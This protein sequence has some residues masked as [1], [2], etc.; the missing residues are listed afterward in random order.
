M[1]HTEP[2]TSPK[3]FVLVFVALIALTVT[4]AMVSFVDLGWFNPVVAFMIASFKMLLVALFFMEVRHSSRVTKITVGA[5]LFWFMIL[6][7]LTL[8]DYL[9]RWWP[10]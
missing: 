4:T 10:T 8:G 2:I 3:T 5:G 1:E 7:V 6:I 9:T